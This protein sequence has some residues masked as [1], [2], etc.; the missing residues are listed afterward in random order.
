MAGTLEIDVDDWK[1]HTEYRNGNNKH[2]ILTIELNLELIIQE[3]VT[4]S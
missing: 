3:K 2:C 4:D 1:A